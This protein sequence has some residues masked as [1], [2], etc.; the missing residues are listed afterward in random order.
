[1]RV[2]HLN[3]GTLCPGSARFILGEGSL[4]T[5]AQ[6]V[7]HCLLLET[8]QGLALV[9]TGLGLRDIQDPSRMGRRFIK[10][11]APRLDPSETAVAQVERL[12]FKREDVRHVL[13]TH[14][15]LDHAGGLSDFPTAE[16]HVFRAEYEA[17]MHPTGRSGRIGYRPRQWAHGPRW[18]P[19]ALDGE[20]WFGFEAVRPIP[21]LGD[22]V[23]L[24]PLVGHSEGHCGVAVRSEGRWL[25][26]A[27]DAYFSHH[28]V[29]PVAPRSP[30]GVALFQRLRSVDNVARL[31]N[32]A[33]LRE[34]VRNHSHEVSVFCAH[35]PTDF[36]RHAATPIPQA[37]ASR[38]VAG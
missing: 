13:P 32:Q 37:Q 16:V 19:H 30:L 5:R 21:G 29:N 8:R 10:R 22:E 28:E 17:A 33:R 31:S 23:L 1:M 36:R 3:C 18:Q 14:L 25:L 2:H 20:R 12:G 24:V 11:N 15:D 6:L 4:F 9:D 38:A 7:C 27:G 34:L 35:C 26:H